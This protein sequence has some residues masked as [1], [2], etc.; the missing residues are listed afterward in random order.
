[1]DA[2]ANP[3]RTRDF[4]LEPL[5]PQ[6]NLADFAAWSSSIDHIKATPGFRPGEWGDDSWPYPMELDDNLDDL[7]M[8]A[9][10]FGRGIAFAYSVIEPVGGDVIG[11]VYVDP[12]E[13]GAADITVRSW[14]RLSHAALDDALATAVAAWLHTAW[15]AT[16][17]RYPGRN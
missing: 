1:M 10:E 4:V 12:D 2:P 6:H 13:T 16:S 14:V 11:C 15:P 7:E 3:P 9:D 17:I 8:H 5:G